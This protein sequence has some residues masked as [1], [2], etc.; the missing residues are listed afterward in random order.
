MH[1]L[2]PSFRDTEITATIN[3]MC[4]EVR[5][6]NKRKN[7]SLSALSS[8]QSTPVMISKPKECSAAKAKQNNASNKTSS[9]LK[10][11]RL[12]FSISNPLSENQPPASQN[13]QF[14]P[15]SYGT[16][17]PG[18]QPYYQ[19]QYYPQTQQTFNNHFVQSPAQHQDYSPNIYNRTIPTFSPSQQQ[20]PTTT[21]SI[22]DE[23]SETSSSECS[24]E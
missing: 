24:D 14:P 18:Y 20:K 21:I 16:M 2:N 10:R 8:N 7:N 5:S 15:H 3:L 11:K 17:P 9:S 6:Q 1:T 13:Y 19:P 22:D 12:D 4:N 23:E